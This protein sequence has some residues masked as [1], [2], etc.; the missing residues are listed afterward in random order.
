MKEQ[1]I[2][3]SNVTYSILIKIYGKARQLDKALAIIQ[4]MKSRGINPGIIVYTCLIQTCIKSGD[5]ATALMKFK[6]MVSEGIVGD[7]VT[8][9]TLLKGCLQFKKFSEACDVFE[10][11]YNNQINITSD[12]SQS[13][14]SQV[15]KSKNVA[16]LSRVSTIEKMAKHHFY[17]APRNSKYTGKPKKQ[18]MYEVQKFTDEEEKE[19]P[20]D[21]IEKECPKFTNSKK[22]LKATAP[23]YK[24]KTNEGVI[25][26]DDD[27]MISETP[28]DTVK[29][30]PVQDKFDEMYPSENSNPMNFQQTSEVHLE[31][32]K[33]KPFETKKS[34]GTKFAKK[35]KKTFDEPLQ[36]TSSNRFSRF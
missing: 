23:E 28:V 33:G 20:T 26:V 17:E 18:F 24:P 2:L 15:Q 13:L 6:E 11:A 36:R 7:Q 25:N 14:V 19:V 8:Y 32:V 21:E 4:E 22:G 16:L 31:K 1:N 3:P 27:F 35:E 12:L 9:S 34:K 10:D 30:V 29:S 5:I